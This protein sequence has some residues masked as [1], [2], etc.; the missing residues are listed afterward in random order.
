MVMQILCASGAANSV[1][2]DLRAERDAF[3]ADKN[4]R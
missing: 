1:S 2:I 4:A 3:I